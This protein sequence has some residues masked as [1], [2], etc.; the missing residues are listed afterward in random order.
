VDRLFLDA[1]VLFSAAWAEGSALNRLWRL[2]GVRL[3][4]SSYVI[5]EAERNLPGSEARERLRTLLASVERVADPAAAL[6]QRA[7]LLL[8]ENDRPVLRAALGARATHLVSGDRRAFG[9]FYGKALAGIE[10]VRPAVYLAPAARRRSTSRAS[11]PSPTRP[12][13]APRR[14]GRRG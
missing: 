11:R 3:L 1:N 9:A 10:I 2:R 14:P 4:A 7:E 8:P 6:D 5:D 13:S 12:S